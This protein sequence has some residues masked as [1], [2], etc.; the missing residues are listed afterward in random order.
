MI[1]RARDPFTGEAVDLTVEGG[2]LAALGPA[3]PAASPALGDATTFVAPG[4]F[5]LQLNGFQGHDYNAPPFT[6]TTAEAIRQAMVRV[7]VTQHLACITTGSRHRMLESLRAVVRARRDPAVARAIPGFH[8]EGPWLSPHD[9]P[10]GAHPRRHIR[11]P[12]WD[13]FQQFQEAAEG[14]IR[15]VTL[16]PEWEGAEAFI[17]K[18]VDQGIVVA[19]G[20]ADV[21]AAAVHSAVAAGV[22]VATHLG[23]GCHATMDRHDNPL[24]QQL[25]EDR[26]WA[27]IIVDGHHLPPP[28]VD[29]MV[30]CK[31]VDR[32][33]LISDAMAAAGLPPGTYTFGELDV[34]VGANRRVALPGTPYLAGSALDL[35]T[36]V[37]NVMQFAGVSLAGALRMASSN[38]W[39]L[40]GDSHRA[41]GLAPGV[42]A[43]LLLFRRPRP[44]APLHLTHTLVAGEV[45]FSAQGE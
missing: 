38:A 17:R 11:P 34:E 22:T 23:N 31:G 44:D 3:E 18:L 19:L 26:L 6:E 21:T 25:V 4:L 1:I 7:G 29:I 9:G 41:R 33:V 32:L 15:L 16:S 30:R 8:L 13:E 2:R 20:H 39:A 36:G 27:T 24:F 12:D 40:L 14:L 43:D 42:P 37:G 28:L 45:V 5:D 10:R 35:L